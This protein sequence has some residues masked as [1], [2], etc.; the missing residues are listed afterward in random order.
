MH[1]ARACCPNLSPVSAEEACGRQ[2]LFRKEEL[3]PVPMPEECPAH[4]HS[5]IGTLV[6]FKFYT[7]ACPT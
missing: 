6:R 1:C 7:C 5:E 2:G 4:Q 3:Q